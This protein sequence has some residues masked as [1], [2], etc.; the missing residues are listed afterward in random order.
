[1]LFGPGVKPMEARNG[2]LVMIK[3][4]EKPF[5][6]CSLQLGASICKNDVTRAWNAGRRTQERRLHIV[7]VPVNIVAVG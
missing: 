4:Q 6:F 3:V 2:K 1:M 5:I 7:N